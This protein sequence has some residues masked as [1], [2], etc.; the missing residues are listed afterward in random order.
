M[1]HLVETKGHFMLIDPVS[2][3]EIPAQRPAVVEFT[4]FFQHRTAMDQIRILAEDLEDS[5]TDE[6]F[7]DTLKESEGDVDLAVEAFKSEFSPFRTSEKLSSEDNTVTPNGE[8]AD[9]TATDSYTDSETE[10][11][12]PKRA[13]KRK[14]D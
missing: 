14:A 4:S 1:K 10:D 3:Q 12:K 7:V 13:S 8:T 2:G 11:D 9:G 5:A 6:A